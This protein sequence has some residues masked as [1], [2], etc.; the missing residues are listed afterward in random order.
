MGAPVALNDGQQTGH[1]GKHRL[2]SHDTGISF[3]KAL[4]CPLG[5]RR[6]VVSTLNFEGINAAPQ[7][8]WGV[9]LETFIIGVALLAGAHCAQSR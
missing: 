7:Q 1:L 9:R 5:K 3:S 8:C 2:V 4:T 6:A